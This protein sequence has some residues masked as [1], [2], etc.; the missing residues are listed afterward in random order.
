MFFLGVCMYLLAHR[1]PISHTSM[2]ILLLLF[3][4]SFAY[5][6]ISIALLY[7]VCA[8]G[9][10]Y[11]AYIPKGPLLKLNSIG[12]YSYGIYILG[13]PIQQAVEQLFPNLSLPIYFIVT[14]STTL[15]LAIISWH[16]IESK[17]LSFKGSI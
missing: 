1:I 13:Y 4:L 5:R 7:L 3:G 16:L 15:F 17:A 6:P 2:T 14:L 9:V 12:D 8:Y 10:F 11:F